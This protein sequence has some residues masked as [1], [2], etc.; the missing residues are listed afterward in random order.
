MRAACSASCAPSSATRSF[1]SSLG[2]DKT[3]RS[4]TRWSPTP[5]GST[6]AMHSSPWPRRR[7]RTAVPRRGSSRCRSRA[8]HGAAWRSTTFRR[9]R[10]RRGAA[11][12][13]YPR[14]S[15]CRRPNGRRSTDSRPVLPRVPRG[16]PCGP[17]VPAREHGP[18]RGGRAAERARRAGLGER[19]RA[20]ERTR[21]AARRD[22]ARPR[23]A[24]EGG[25]SARL[26]GAPGARRPL[27]RGGS[28]HDPG[29]MTECAGW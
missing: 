8:I 6:R 29:G 19:G 23:R 20:A 26:P 15:R 28:Q 17:R 27:V 7:F 3:R 22:V 9:S 1:R 21:A 10:L 25:V 18:H 13:R 24:D 14:V 11:G 2:A 16:A 12:P 4:R 5:A